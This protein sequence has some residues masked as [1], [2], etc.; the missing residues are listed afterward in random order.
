MIFVFTIFPTKRKDARIKWCFCAS[1]M[2][3]MAI[4]VILPSGACICF[5]TTSGHMCMKNHIDVLILDATKL[6]VKIQTF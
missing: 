1:T 4:N 3:M 5:S 6:L 2:K